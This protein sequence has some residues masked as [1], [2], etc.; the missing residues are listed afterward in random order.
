MSQVSSDIVLFETRGPIAVLTLNRPKANAFNAALSKALAAAFRR[1][2][3]D[4]SLRV[5][6]VTG[7]GEKFF[8]GG[9]DMDEAASGVKDEDVHG[10]DGFAGIRFLHTL[11][12]P[13][14]AALNGYTIGGGFELALACDMIVAAD[15]ARFWFPEIQ[16]GFIADA[17][18]VQML[19]RYVPKKIAA[20]ILL[21]GR[22]FEL[23]EAHRHGLVNAVAPKAELMAKALS[24]AEMI[25]QGAPLSIEATKE[26]MRATE[27]L[28]ERRA[29]CGLAELDLPVYRRMM[30]STDF[31]EGPKAFTQ[32]RSARF[33][34]N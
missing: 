8:S 13:V 11:N 26:V 10:P 22:W 32:G 20:E 9:W 16:R 25:A 24:Y 19:Q 18:G 21:T 14:I 1:F 6:I 34:G 31:F 5:A 28:P 27:Q 4:E 15:N 3:T 7:Q 29:L 17:G 2:A 12:K 23:D 30:Q 33:T